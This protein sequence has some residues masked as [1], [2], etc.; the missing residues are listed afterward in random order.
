MTNANDG[1]AFMTAGE[2]NNK[3]KQEERDHML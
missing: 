3:K 2:E 1:L